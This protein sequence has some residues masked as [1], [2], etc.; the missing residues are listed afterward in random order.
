MVTSISSLDETSICENAGI[1]EVI[2]DAVMTQGLESALILTNTSNVI[3]V[4]SQS[5]EI[6][7][8]GLQVGEYNISQI[9]YEQVSGLQIGVNTSDLSGCFAWIII[10]SSLMSII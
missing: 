8:F 9:V 5:A 2:T 6:D 1:D 3:E 4:I 7:I 10:L